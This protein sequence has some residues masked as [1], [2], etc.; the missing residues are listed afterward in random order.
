MDSL[1][2]ISSLSIPRGPVG[3]GAFTYSRHWRL[4]RADVTRCRLCGTAKSS[5]RSGAGQRSGCRGAAADTLPSVRSLCH[6]YPVRIGHLYAP[7][8]PATKPGSARC[9]V[10]TAQL[11]VCWHSLRSGQAPYL[12]LAERAHHASCLSPPWTVWRPR[13]AGRDTRKQCN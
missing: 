5:Y 6:E 12:T 1:P 9:A 10:T 8:L 4:G 11:G 13:A 3:I 7:R 2:L